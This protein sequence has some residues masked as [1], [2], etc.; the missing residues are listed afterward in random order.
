MTPEELRQCLE[1]AFGDLEPPYLAE[2]SESA[3]IDGFEDAVRAVSGTTKRWQELRPLIQYQRLGLAIFLL[4]PRAWQYYLPAYLYAITDPDDV[5]RY[6]SPILDTLWYENEHGDQLTYE[7]QWERCTALFTDSQSRGIAHF[8]A[9]LLSGI[10]DPSVDL[11]AEV[12]WERGRIE[13]M[14][15]KY[16]NAWL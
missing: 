11:S 13:H 2:V 7:G 3:D 15:K 8:L 6:L 10:D 9:Q 4:T 16:W 12:D 5:W 1:E 14:L